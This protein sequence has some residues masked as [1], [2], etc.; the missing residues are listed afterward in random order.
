MR[1]VAIAATLIAAFAAPAHAATP[2]NL[3]TGPGGLLALDAANGTA[4][5]VVGRNGARPFTLLR[6]SGRARSTLGTFGEPTSRD[7]DVVARPDG[8]TVVWARAISGGMEYSLAS[9]ANGR[10]GRAEV[11]ASGTGPPRLALIGGLPV[12][13]RPD[14]FGDVALGAETL[15]G[16]G[17]ERRHLPLDTTTVGDDT[18]VLDLAQ[19]PSSATLTVMGSGAPRAPVLRLNRRRDLEGTI[20]ADRDRIYVAFRNRGTAYLATAARRPDARWRIEPLPGP[21]GGAGAPAIARSGGATFVAYSQGRPRR[22]VFV[23]RVKAGTRRLTRLTIH[24]DDDSRPRIAPAPNGQVFVGW[25]RERRNAASG[26]ALLVRT[27]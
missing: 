25:T 2:V 5:A 7:P 19:A 23:A 17:I 9:L 22:D 3:G 11:V 12:I 24:P 26:T 1:R 27:G 14:T 18:L 6:S 16:D 4:Y 15:T 8:A 10:L 21:G 13:A 20:T